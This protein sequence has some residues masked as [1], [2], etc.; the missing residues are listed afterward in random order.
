MEVYTINRRIYTGFI[1]IDCL[2]RE[3]EKYLQGINTDEK[4]H[5]VITG[6]WTANGKPFSSYQLTDANGEILT[7]FEH[8]QFSRDRHG[9][10]YL[11]TV[12]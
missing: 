5:F 2:Y 11:E 9:I 12:N 8:L 4:Q 10:F 1:Y 6:F 7:D 3:D